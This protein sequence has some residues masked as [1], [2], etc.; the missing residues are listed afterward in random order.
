MM[1]AAPCQESGLHGR[2]GTCPTKAKRRSH[3]ERRSATE[4]FR[5][6]FGILHDTARGRLP[7]SFDLLCI[8]SF[9]YPTVGDVDVFLVLFGAISQVGLFTDQQVH[10]S[11]GII[12]FLVDVN[13]LLKIGNAVI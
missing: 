4:E 10:I 7:S 11:H 12:I 13:S 3:R 5:L 2:S 8:Q 9:L 1:W 6:L